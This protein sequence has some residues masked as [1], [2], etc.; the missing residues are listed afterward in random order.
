MSW[1]GLAHLSPPLLAPCLLI[2]AFTVS[3][4]S[5]KHVDF[6]NMGN[7][8]S[9]GLQSRT[10]RLQAEEQKAVDT[11]FDALSISASRSVLSTSASRL[12]SKGGKKARKTINLESLKAYAEGTL[13]TSILTRLY[14]GV[15]S[16]NVGGKSCEEISKEQFTMFILDILYD[17][18]GRKGNIILNMISVAKDQPVNKQQVREVRKEKQ[19]L[20]LNFFFFFFKW[21]THGY[22][23]LGDPH[24]QEQHE[25]IVVLCLHLTGDSRCFLFTIYPSFA[26]YICSGYNDHYMYLN[27][28][29]RTLPNGL[30]M[31][32]QCSYFGL[33]LDSD[34][35][36]GQSKAKPRCTTFS[37]PQL[38]A[39][40]DFILQ[41]LEVWAVGNPCESQSS[42]KSIL[43]TDPEAWAL[44]EMAGME[45]KSEGL[46]EPME[47]KGEA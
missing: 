43:D 24:L 21:P 47:E 35:G 7:S 46:R 12:E 16:V 44:L 5:E 8:E 45:R 28:G 34:Y 11:V 4:F 29:Q 32:G 42:H 9:Q 23:F 2:I 10:S 33:W 31:G 15:K 19:R 30:G 41:S 27:H 38:S 6:E 40:E 18:T 14:N 17:N 26:T 25:N 3:F 1:G 39:K 22:A 37:S 36:K 13:S 20:S